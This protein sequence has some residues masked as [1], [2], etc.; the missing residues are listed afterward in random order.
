MVVRGRHEPPRAHDA[1]HGAVE[2]ASHHLERPEEGDEQEEVVRALPPP[3][4]AIC[5]LV[6]LFVW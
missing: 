4:G 2:H 6:G 3:P 1:R 5:L